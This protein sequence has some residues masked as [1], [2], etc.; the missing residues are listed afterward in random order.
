MRKI[1]FE[2]TYEQN[3]T[4]RFGEKDFLVSL[5]LRAVF[6]VSFKKGGFGEGGSVDPFGLESA[7]SSIGIS[8]S[9]T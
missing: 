5:F 3:S 9:K 7:N 4:G 2:V 8:S 1:P 6:R